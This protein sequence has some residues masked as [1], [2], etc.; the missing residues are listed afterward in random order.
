VRRDGVN[1]GKGRMSGGRV[2]STL[3]EAKGVIVMCS[4]EGRGDGRGTRSTD[5]RFQT[6][7]AGVQSGG[8]GR[9]ES[10]VRW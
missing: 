5:T 9:V 3:E 10:A 6:S 2:N 8:G 4:G 7:G 1:Q